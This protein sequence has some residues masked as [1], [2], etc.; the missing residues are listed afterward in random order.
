MVDVVR[1]YVKHG[2]RAT[3]VDKNG[4][5]PLIVACTAGDEAVVEALMWGGADPN[6]VRL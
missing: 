3:V 1:L 6:Q 2:A 5:T 4:N